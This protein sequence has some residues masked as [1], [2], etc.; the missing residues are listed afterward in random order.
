MWQTKHR[1]SKPCESSCCRSAG[2]AVRWCN[3]T[4]SVALRTEAP[5]PPEE[6][7]SWSWSVSPHCSA[8]AGAEEVRLYV[9]PYSP[10]RDR[11]WCQQWAVRL[12]FVHC[13]HAH[14]FRVPRANSLGGI[15]FLYR[16]GA[17]PD[18]GL[19]L[20]HAE[21]TRVHPNQSDECPCAV[22]R[23]AVPDEWVMQH[24]DETVG[25]TE[26]PCCGRTRAHRSAVV[27]PS[28][29]DS[30]LRHAHAARLSSMASI[31]AQNGSR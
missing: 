31:S 27:V 25:A 15:L 14:P 28:V 20:V 24:G 6:Q 13:S 11:T 22:L 18:T 5:P 10:V 8:Y 30:S 29:A 9:P 7:D 3:V 12:R 26:V 2:T 23:V 17:F 4:P 21:A 1:L 19:H 16:T